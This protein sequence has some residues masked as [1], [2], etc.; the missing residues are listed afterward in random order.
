MSTVR[1]N[2]FAPLVRRLAAS[3]AF[4][5]RPF[6]LVDVGASGGV[7]EFWQQ[8]AP[9]FGAVGFDPMIEEC[10]R[11]NAAPEAS[12]G[13][14]YVDAFVG[15]EDYARDF[16]PG[17]RAGWS[18]APFERSSAARAQRILG[19]SYGQTVS[20]SGA[21]T[22]TTRRT[23][24]DAFLAGEGR[25][26]VDFIK[27]DTDGHDYEVLHGA[28]KTLGERRVLGVLVEVAFQGV[29][30]PHSQLFG[31]IDRLLREHGFTLFDLETYRYSRASLPDMF[32]YDLPAQTYAGQVIAGDAL[33]LRD[34]CAPGYA[35]RW[36]FAPTPVELAKLACLQEL[37]GMPDCAA[38]L[39]AAHRDA[40]SGILDAA[41]ALDLL[42]PDGDY[43]ALV[44]R[45]EADPRAFFASQSPKDSLARM[46]SELDWLRDQYRAVLGSRSWR[47]T[48]PLRRLSALLRP[49]R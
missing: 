8:F 46:K 45:F 33:Y 40:L 31:N 20:V 7:G 36:S 43:R 26:Y 2:R 27:T 29:T 13:V 12:P 37:F 35:G 17:A 19:M 18:D 9:D 30:H 47:L 39:L 14:R 24:L 1:L 10:A 15:S 41:A 49:R 5:E 44:A 3:R 42:V 25:A 16:P 28:R 38:E 48:A 21:Q 6:Y 11:L 32:T 4:R 23:S 34:V 22:M